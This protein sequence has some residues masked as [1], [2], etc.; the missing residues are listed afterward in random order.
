MKKF[1]ENPCDL[2]GINAVSTQARDEFPCS[3]ERCTEVNVTGHD[4]LYLVIAFSLLIKC[5]A[6]WFSY[7]KLTRVCI[8][9]QN[10]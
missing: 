3:D 10:Y 9:S 5:S 6:V 7:Y 8:L 2:T 1:L 4:S